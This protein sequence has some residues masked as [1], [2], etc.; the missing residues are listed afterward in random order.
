MVCRWCVC[1]RGRAVGGSDGISKHTKVPRT[2]HVATSAACP[3]NCLEAN[4]KQRASTKLSRKQ[5]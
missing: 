4:L 3:R 5:I 2:A 1:V